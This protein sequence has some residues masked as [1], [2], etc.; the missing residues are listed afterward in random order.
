MRL[1]LPEIKKK[2]SSLIP[3]GIEYVVE[4]SLIHI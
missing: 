4:L 1:T 3:D 2:V